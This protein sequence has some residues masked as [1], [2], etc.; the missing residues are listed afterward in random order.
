[1]L[2]GLSLLSVSEAMHRLSKLANIGSVYLVEYK[3]RRTNVLITFGER[4]D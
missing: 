2:Y 4:V 3:N 1:M